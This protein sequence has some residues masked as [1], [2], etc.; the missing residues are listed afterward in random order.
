[1]AR[2][3]DPMFL[4]VFDIFKLGV[5][6][7]SSH[8]MGPMTAAARFLDDL[9]GGAEKIPG[10]GQLSRLGA[11]L[12]GS[13]AFTGKGHATDRAVVLGLLGFRPDTLDPDAA[14]ALEAEVRKS[15]RIAPPG[16]GDLAFDPDRDL[17]FDYG[18]PLPGHANGLILRA[19]DE[20]GNTY[21]TQTYYSV[22]GGFVV[23]AAELEAQKA[24]LIAQI[25]TKLADSVVAFLVETL[26]HDVDLGAQTQYLTKMLDEHK[27]DFSGKVKDEG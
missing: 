19:Y 18:P 8:T 17:V 2:V 5:G 12:H 3:P 11:S 26:Q 13:L 1:M 6:P 27:A 16:L 25:D 14:E 22:G 20:R 21:L 15:G 4:S 24:Q 7:S 9:R 10:A 23:T